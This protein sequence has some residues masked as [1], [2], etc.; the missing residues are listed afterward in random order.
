[1]SKFWSFKN[2]SDEEVE[3]RL[4]GEII[5][6]DDAWFYEWLGIPSASPNAF[7]QALAEHNGKNI[8]VWIDS[9]GGDVFAGAGMYNAIKEHKG[10]VTAKI[11]GKAVSAASII[12]MAA[13]EIIMSPV[14]IMMIH[15]PYPGSGVRGDARELRHAADVLDEVKETIINA[16]Q[17]KTGKDREL[18]SKM[19]DEETW[20]S[21]KRAVAD[22]FADGVL[23]AEASEGEGAI[24]NSYSFSRLAI[25][26]SA[27][28]VMFNFFEKWKSFQMNQTNLSLKEDPKLEI[29]NV[30]E[31]KQHFPE[32]CNQLIASA[33]ATVSAEAT[34]AERNRIKEIDDIA[35]S[36]PGDLVNKAKFLEPVNAQQLAFQA[37]KLDAA[38]G[39]TFLDQ[40]NQEIAPANKVP[41]AS[42]DDEKDKEL[43]VINAI[44]TAANQKRQG[45]KADA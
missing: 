7:R 20:M 36:L 25:Q 41:G 32:L 30:E 19:M 4:S 44:A 1:M 11:D 37:L 5:S 22:G 35:N 27:D 42:Q 28:S 13:D 9:W 2:L 6:D 16:Y 34:V 23:Y 15:N 43:A 12:A 40:R 3:L 17:N 18:I 10:K 14:S 26:N 33:T 8:T 38:A 29:K 24:H 21:A 45:V 39:R 31:L